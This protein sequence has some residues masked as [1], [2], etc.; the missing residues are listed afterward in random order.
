MKDNKFFKRV[1]VLEFTLTFS[2]HYFIEEAG[3]RENSIILLKNKILGIIYDNNGVKEF[4]ITSD[5]INN[6]VIYKNDLEMTVII[7][8]KEETNDMKII[9]RV[10]RII[11]G[12]KFF[13]MMADNYICAINPTVTDYFI[14]PDQTIL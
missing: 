4:F 3:S 5:K 1:D 7:R 11:Y 13:Y 12:D 14:M 10:N 6:D 8:D 2:N 9:T